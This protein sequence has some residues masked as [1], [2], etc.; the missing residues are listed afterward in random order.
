MLLASYAAC[1]RTS[2]ILFFM[3][4]MFFKG[5]AY[6]SSRANPVDL[7]PNYAGVL[8]GIMNGSGALAGLLSPIFVPMFIT[9]VS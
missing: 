7:S 4:M 8:M 3:C 5:L 6:S 9:G 1:D 2:V